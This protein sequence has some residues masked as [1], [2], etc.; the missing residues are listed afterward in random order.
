M[1]D[2]YVDISGDGGLK[3]K[4]KKKGS[5]AV[6]KKGQIVFAHY[7]GKLESS[8]TVFDSSRG[9]PH[10]KMGFYFAL[11]KGEVIKGGDVGFAS[12]RVGE[13]AT[14]RVRADYGY[15]EAGIPSM[16]ISREAVLLFEVE[17]L[18]AKDMTSTE[19]RE[20]DAHVASLRRR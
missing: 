9:K 12:M 16:G 2:D 19:R 13:V 6:P 5:G 18:N 1:D 14:L 20:L 7:T 10:R 4:I 3:K 11:G 8:G 17:L 15:G